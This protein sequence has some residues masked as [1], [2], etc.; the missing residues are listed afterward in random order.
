MAP[1]T[2]A[3]WR[4]KGLDAQDNIEEALAIIEQVV[5][6]WKHLAT[7]EIQGELRTMNNK[8][9]AD[10]DVFQDAVNAMYTARGESAPE[11]NLTKLWEAFNE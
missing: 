3:R 11:W 5:D 8:L 4:A 7:P 10:I 2:E 9:W 1:V 6:V